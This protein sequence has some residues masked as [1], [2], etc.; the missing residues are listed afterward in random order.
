MDPW[1]SDIFF[2]L[3]INWYFYITTI[4]SVIWYWPHRSFSFKPSF[5]C[6]LCFCQFR[7]NNLHRGFPDSKFMGPTWGPSGADRTQLGPILSPWTLP[8]GLVTEIYCGCIYW[9][10]LIHISVT[11]IVISPN[12]CLT[13]PSELVRM[14]S[15]NKIFPR[16]YPTQCWPKVFRQLTCIAHCRLNHGTTTRGI[17]WKIASGIF[18][19][20]VWQSVMFTVICL[21]VAIKSLIQATP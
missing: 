5:L 7:F 9:I 11:L 20:F 15:A 6:F 13:E 17:H 18:N 2:S 3:F 21:D 1:M 8:P 14:S 10:F 12:V 4:F 19:H 16:C